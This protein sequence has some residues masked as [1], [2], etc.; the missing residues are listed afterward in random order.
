MF[1]SNWCPYRI[2]FLSSS[3]WFFCD[4]SSSIDWKLLMAPHDDD[5]GTQLSCAVFFCLSQF[6]PFFVV[7]QKI[8]KTPIFFY[9]S[10]LMRWIW[11]F[12]LILKYLSSYCFGERWLTLEVHYGNIMTGWWN[13]FSNFHFLS[14]VTHIIILNFN[15]WKIF[16][17]TVEKISSVV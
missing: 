10:L 11:I 3:I 9:I 17:I 15:D 5:N 4:Y 2:V 16:W 8:P 6:H 7:I 13:S 1:F 12:L 14:T